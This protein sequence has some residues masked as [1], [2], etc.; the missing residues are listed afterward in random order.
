MSVMVKKYVYF[1]AAYLGGSFT[2]VTDFDSV[3]RCAGNKEGEGISISAFNSM[4][5]HF[6]KALSVNNVSLSEQEEFLQLLLSFKES[7]CQPD[8][9]NMSLYVEVVKSKIYLDIITDLMEKMSTLPELAEFADKS[10]AK[11]KDVTDRVACLLSSKSA[12]DFNITSDELEHA[13][14]SQGIPEEYY[15]IVEFLG[16]LLEDLQID[17]D[18]VDQLKQFFLILSHEKYKDF[19]NKVIKVNS[20]PANSRSSLV[21]SLLSSSSLD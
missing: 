20:C 7:F 13:L 3:H 17:Y 10:T 12:E 2:I 21:Y 11:H 15:K 8:E 14:E 18:V 9:R 5:S 1:I 4:L 16:E 6:Q 19:V